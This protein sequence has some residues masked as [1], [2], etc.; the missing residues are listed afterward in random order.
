M[1]TQPPSP[2]VGVIVNPSARR[3]ACDQCHTQKL[4]CTKLEDCTVCVRCQ[5]LNRQCIWSPPS[6]SGRPARTTAKETL[7]RRSGRSELTAREKHRKRS[8]NILDMTPEESGHSDGAREHVHSNPGK[9]LTPPS[10]SP[11]VE[12]AEVPPS[13]RPPSSA[14]WNMSDILT[15]PSPRDSS[16]EN[17]FP[18]WWVS[19]SVVPS[20]PN[21]T[22]YFQLPVNGSASPGDQPGIPEDR[23]APS[24]LESLRDITRELS[25]VNLSLLDLE[26][27]LHA[28]PWGPMFASPAAVITKL[29]A[30]GSGDQL[31]GTL[32]HG[33]PLIEI[34][35]HT[36]RFIDIAKQTS[37]YFASLPTTSASTSTSSS[38]AQPPSHPDSN[39][40]SSQGSSPFSRPGDGHLPYTAS[41]PSTT[42]GDRLVCTASSC[43]SPTALLFTAGYARILDIYLTVLTQTSNFVHALSMQSRS[44]GPDYRQRM[45]PV[46]PPLQWGGF[47]PA[48][49]GALQ[50][51][52]IIQVISYLLTEVERALGI[53]EWEHEVM[54]REQSQ[55]A[56]RRSHSYPQVHGQSCRSDDFEGDRVVR[57]RRR[58]LSPAMIELVVKGE[59]SGNNDCQ[60][61]KIGALRRELRQLKEEIENSMHI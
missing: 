28:E 46:I 41:S 54:M 26:Q 32:A 29:S 47:R 15:F 18:P 52:M 10:P 44:G 13:S 58:L 8:S 43:D 6:R 31:D 20:M 24:G 60:R 49:Y 5:R 38:T 27:S 57:T 61:G 3:A 19:D 48:N 23:S 45:H 35:K 9:T 1:S 17:L 59:E 21:L 51:L 12:I 30:C 25:N 37:V 11:P 34:F 55:A 2:H 16:R 33:Y 50:I 14:E 56:E 53:D 22:E 42:R 39:D 7:M 4:R 36:Q 40:T